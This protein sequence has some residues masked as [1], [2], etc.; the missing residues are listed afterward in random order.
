VCITSNEY[1]TAQ[2]VNYDKDVAVGNVAVDAV[3]LVII[4]SMA[5][6]STRAFNTSEP[7][8]STTES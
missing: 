2:L 4:Y 5:L 1:C 3:G 7:Q 8:T 6:I